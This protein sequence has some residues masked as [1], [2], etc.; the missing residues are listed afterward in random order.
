MI[1]SIKDALSHTEV[2]ERDNKTFIAGKKYCSR[3]IGDHNCIFEITVISRTDKTLCYTY[4][5]RTRRSK[6][7]LDDYG[8]YIRPDN[9]SM[10]PTFHAFGKLD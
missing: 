5:N 1:I 9:Y 10:S 2:D 3:S 4:G 6:I 8:E 7:H